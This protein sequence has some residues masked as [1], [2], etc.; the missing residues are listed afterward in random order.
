L[1]KNCYFL[2]IT[3]FVQGP[4]LASLGVSKD[5]SHRPAMVAAF[6]NSTTAARYGVWGATVRGGKYAFHR[7]DRITSNVD[8]GAIK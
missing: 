1:F 8:L 7:T 3:I 6:G 2:H 4:Q 5:F